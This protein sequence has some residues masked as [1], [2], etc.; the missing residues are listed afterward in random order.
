MS[1]TD[2]ERGIFDLEEPFW[3]TLQE[4]YQLIFCR[5]ERGMSTTTNLCVQ[6]SPKGCRRDADG[7]LRC[8]VKVGATFF[9]MTYYSKG[10]RVF[11]KRGPYV[12]RDIYD[13]A[14]ELAR[15]HI[16]SFLQE[17]EKQK[18]VD[19]KVVLLKTFRNFARGHDAVP[20]H[21]RGL[22]CRSGE[23]RDD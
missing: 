9:E 2:Q 8:E 5:G 15:W 19:Q 10:P 11:E 6:L 22:G 18:I 1:V 3:Y 20:K 21:I 14:Y 23:S 13:D 12:R 7:I 17:E 4:K 16:D